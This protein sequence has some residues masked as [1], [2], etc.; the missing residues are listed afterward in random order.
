MV[1]LQRD[2]GVFERFHAVVQGLV[3]ATEFRHLG[4]Q[5]LD[6][7]VF[8]GVRVRQFGVLVEFLFDRRKS[9][10]QTGDLRRQNDR[11]QCFKKRGRDAPR[12]RRLTCDVR[13]T[14]RSSY[15]VRR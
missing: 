6:G 2:G 12:P 10:V 3:V 4:P 15:A 14:I 9:R 5:D 1:R 13:L 11:L 8:G 7:R